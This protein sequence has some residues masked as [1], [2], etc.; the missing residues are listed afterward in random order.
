[1]NGDKWHLS[2]CVVI[3]PNSPTEQT[4]V[5]ETSI[6]PLPLLSPFSLCCVS[7]FLPDTQVQTWIKDDRYIA[8]QRAGT[9][10][11]TGEGNM[12]ERQR[13]CEE[14]FLAWHGF[15][16]RLTK[17]AVYKNQP[18]MFYWADTIYYLQPSRLGGQKTEETHKKTKRK[19]KTHSPLSCRF[20]TMMLCGKLMLVITLICGSRFCTASHRL[21]TS[22]FHTNESESIHTH[23]Q[24]KGIWH[25]RI[26]SS[27]CE[28]LWQD[29]KN[30]TSLETVL[31]VCP[32]VCVFISADAEIYLA[33]IRNVLGSRPN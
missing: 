31:Y 26:G 25:P 2:I 11:R 1:M 9:K 8:V 18:V 16:F 13:E 4:W 27:R 15:V 28:R 5:Y 19:K 24:L 3:I 21:N 23:T 29:K 22:H 7:L 6:Y 20:L 33:L 17:N 32:C 10:S 30:K 12:E 14:I